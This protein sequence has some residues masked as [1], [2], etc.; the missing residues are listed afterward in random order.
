[1]KDR[2]IFF[3]ALMAATV[4][5]RA[6]EDSAWFDLGYVEDQIYY[7]DFFECSLPIPDGWHTKIDEDQALYKQALESLEGT[8]D[9]QQY[10]NINKIQSAILIIISKYTPGTPVDFN[11]NII[12]LIEN[13]SK[14]PGIRTGADYLY[15][16]SKL[17]AQTNPNAKITSKEYA[18]HDFSKTFYAMDMVTKV[19]GMKMKQTFYS[20]ICK[21]FS[22]SM[23]CSSIDKST[24]A[25]LYGVISGIE[26]KGE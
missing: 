1:M 19:M 2:L 9:R 14:A 13:V 12:L 16:A 11:P 10:A 25:E 3:M 5:S 4:V 18:R 15:H 22:F 24:A 7:N 23:I 6:E 26:F 8:V 17:A 20:T 21:G